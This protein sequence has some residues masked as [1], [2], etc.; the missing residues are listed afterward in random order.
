MVNAKVSEP[1][2]KYIKS[3]HFVLDKQTFGRDEGGYLKVMIFKFNA[4]M[5]GF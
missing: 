4:D 1:L 2:G 3:I 5:L